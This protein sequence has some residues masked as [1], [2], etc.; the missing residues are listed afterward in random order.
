MWRKKFLYSNCVSYLVQQLIFLL[1]KKKKFL[2][3]FTPITLFILQQVFSCKCLKVFY[4]IILKILFS[5]LI[6][7]MFEF[8]HLSRW[9]CNVKNES[10]VVCQFIFFLDILLIWH[11]Q[12][13][14]T[15]PNHVY[16]ISFITYTLQVQDPLVAS[17]SH[18]LVDEIH[19]RGMNEDFLLIILRDLLPRRPDLRLILM[20]A[21]INAEMFSRYFG[22]APT[23]HIPVNT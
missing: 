3:V 15:E 10:L 13:L 14:F 8:I 9:V 23:I 4:S 21:T 12:M 18:L 16:H 22:N 17:V 19:E 1:V 2:V 5:I 20:S 6:Q 7:C 11:N